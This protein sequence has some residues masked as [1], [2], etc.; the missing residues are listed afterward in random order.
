MEYDLD[1]C[2]RLSRTNIL[3]VQTFGQLFDGFVDW[4]LGLASS[5]PPDDNV[6]LIL[7]HSLL[8]QRRLQPETL[9]K[10]QDGVAGFVRVRD[11]VAG[12]CLTDEGQDTC[13]LRGVGFAR[14]GLEFH[15]VAEGQAA[16]DA[17]GDAV[18]R[19]EGV[20]HGVGEAEA[21]FGVLAQEAERGEGGEEELRDGLRV[22]GVG[23]VGLRQIG[24]E[25]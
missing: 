23:G 5:R 7:T 4:A 20:A 19:A 8:G 25:G 21:A 6:N 9:H 17:V 13:D 22:V 2:A 12:S 18:G 1:F 3:L 10:V 15:D 11:V 24:E 16:G 14:V